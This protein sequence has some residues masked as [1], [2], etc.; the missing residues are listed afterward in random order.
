M[1]TLLVIILT[2]CLH[3]CC[4]KDEVPLAYLVFEWLLVFSLIIAAGM[5]K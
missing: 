1:G 4:A 2:V 5:M 3:R